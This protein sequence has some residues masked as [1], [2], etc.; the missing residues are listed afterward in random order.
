M[1]D[2]SVIVCSTGGME[3]GAHLWKCVALK[4]FCV[5]GVNDM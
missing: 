2:S 3:T 4:E 1:S 5:L